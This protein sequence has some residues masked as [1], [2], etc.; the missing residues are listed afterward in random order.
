MLRMMTPADT[1]FF[2]SVRKEFSY[3]NKTV[4]MM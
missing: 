3:R 1:K 4:V 2:I